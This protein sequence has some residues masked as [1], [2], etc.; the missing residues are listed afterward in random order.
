MRIHGAPWVSIFPGL[1]ISAAV[2]AA[3]LLGDALRDIWDP[4]LKR[5]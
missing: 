2:F 4:R 5:L 1:A 3:N